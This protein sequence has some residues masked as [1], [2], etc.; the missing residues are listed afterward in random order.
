MFGPTAE[1]RFCVAH[2]GHNGAIQVTLEVPNPLRKNK[3]IF[4]GGRASFN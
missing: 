2:H 1:V 3:I 4:R